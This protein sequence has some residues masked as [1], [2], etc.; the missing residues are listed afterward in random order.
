MTGQVVGLINITTF[1]VNIIFLYLRMIQHYK[2]HKK[3]VTPQIAIHYR[4]LRSA[5]MLCTFSLS[6][7]PISLYIAKFV[8]FMFLLT[9]YWSI[10]F[11]AKLWFVFTETR[12]IHAKVKS[13]SD[14]TN[15]Y[16]AGLI[17]AFKTLFWM[18]TKCQRAKNSTILCMYILTKMEDDIKLQISI[19]AQ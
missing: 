16:F 12:H 5:P 18:E 14:H 1:Q 19:T 13:A 2:Q 17:L 10:K 3:F 9:V 11:Y 8:R 4:C 15:L 7:N 6:A